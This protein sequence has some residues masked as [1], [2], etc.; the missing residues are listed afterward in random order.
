M[1]KLKIDPEFEALIPPLTQEEFAELEQ[2]IL[3]DG[4]RHPLVI[5]K[6]IVVDGHNR[7]KICTQHGKAFKS[8]ELERI[9]DRE[10]VLLWIISNQ[11]GR[12]NV[13]QFQRTVLALKKEEIIAARAKRKMEAGTNQHS[14][15]STNLSKGTPIDT[16]REIAMEAGVSEGTVSKVKKIQAD[17]VPAV[18]EAARVGKIKIDV[19]AAVATLPPEEQLALAIKGKD[20][21]KIAAKQVREAKKKKETLPPRVSH[22]VKPASTRALAQSAPAPSTAEGD[23][24]PL[25]AENAELL[26]RV[27][28]LTVA[29]GCAQAENI[30]LDKIAKS[31]DP[32]AAALTEVKRLTEA[33]R[34]LE[35]RV[36]ALQ[37][38]NATLALSNAGDGEVAFPVS[39]QQ[40]P[41][42][43]Q[44]EDIAQSEHA[45][46][47]ATAN[48]VCALPVIH[49]DAGTA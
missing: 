22:S 43:G 4:C 44:A 33:C 41:T 34:E 27:A 13:I 38:E 26:A 36:A 20:A 31:D 30:I 28:E 1:N 14:T 42:G 17:A 15:P 35:I 6:G 39:E 25:R 45:E 12:R 18:F 5:W 48:A 40:L 7:L 29:L 19:A 3:R 9:D 24:V 47:V 11:L 16:R 21:M 46:A 49:V 37:S 8:T 32:L 10:Q 2:N 23:P